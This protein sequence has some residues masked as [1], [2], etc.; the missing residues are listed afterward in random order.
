MRASC[1]PA[2]SEASCILF[3]ERPVAN[4]AVWLVFEDATATV[5]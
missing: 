1:G 5:K 4:W 3:V 2:I